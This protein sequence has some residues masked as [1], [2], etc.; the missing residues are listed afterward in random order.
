MPVMT[1][2]DLL[3]LVKARDQGCEDAKALKVGDEFFGAAPAGK[4]RGYCYETPEMKFYIDGYLA[5]LDSV[6]V[7]TDLN[8]IITKINKA[9]TDK[10]YVLVEQAGYVGE[11]DVDRF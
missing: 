5:S 11:R 6:R 2:E 4:K 8:N 10:P 7:T 3:K 9:T 1:E